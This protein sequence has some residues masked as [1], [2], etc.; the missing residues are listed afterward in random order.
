MVRRI[1]GHDTQGEPSD[2]AHLSDSLPLNTP[3]EPEIALFSIPGSAPGGKVQDVR[4]ANRL[5]LPD[6]DLTASAELQALAASLM[7]AAADAQPSAISSATDAANTTGADDP[8]TLID[9]PAVTASHDAAGDL[10]LYSGQADVL[11]LTADDP[12]LEWFDDETELAGRVAFHHGLLGK[13][14]AASQVSARLLT[15]VRSIAV[16]LGWSRLM[17]GARA[18]SRRAWSIAGNLPTQIAVF[19]ARSSRLKRSREKALRAWSRAVLLSARIEVFDAASRLKRLRENARH[20][21]SGAARWSAGQATSLRRTALAIPLDDV[22]RGALFT[23]AVVTIVVVLARLDWTRPVELPDLIADTPDSST[24]LLEAPSTTG[25]SDLLAGD[26]LAP[27]DRLAPSLN[28][29]ARG[30]DIGI[31]AADPV[32]TLAADVQRDAGEDAARGE[33]ATP[34]VRRS[35]PAAPV[36]A[37]RRGLTSDAVDAAAVTPPSPRGESATRGLGLDPPMAPATVAGLAPVDDAPPPPIADAVRTEAPP[38]ETSES[39]AARTTPVNTPADSDAIVAALSQLELAYERR[40]A[41][42]AKAVWPTVDARALAR[43]FDSLRSQSVEFDGCRVKVTGGTGEV[44]CRGT[45]TYVPR[46][47]SQFARTESRQWMFRLEKGND[48]WVITR[49]AAR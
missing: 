46:V 35:E 49:A 39:A 5:M 32:G 6:L 3:D 34:E 4:R 30:G 15:C 26:Q 7:K 23:A 10:P 16:L 44:Q 17:E 37:A 9:V 19:R 45:T 20:A 47:G 31:Q 18:T 13:A 48:R 14:S 21:L 8:A 12:G 2:P 29:D 25:D 40:D 43:A 1:P 42:L 36:Q 28:D 41:N 11:E 22:I 33:P 27:F 24:S 38:V